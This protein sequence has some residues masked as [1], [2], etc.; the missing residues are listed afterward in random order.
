MERGEDNDA[1]SP[2]PECSTGN[3]ETKVVPAAASTA[4]PCGVGIRFPPAAPFCRE[5]DQLAGQRSW[6]TP[7]A[8]VV[9]LQDEGMNAFP[10]FLAYSEGEKVDVIPRVWKVVEE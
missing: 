2:F 4:P 7:F 6:S 8:L 1:G 10:N 9:F 3:E 5:G